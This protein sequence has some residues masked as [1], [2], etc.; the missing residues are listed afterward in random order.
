MKKLKSSL[1]HNLPPRNP[2]TNPK[3]CFS[4]CIRRPPYAL[5]YHL[6]PVSIEQSPGNTA[7]NICAAMVWL[8]DKNIR[9]L[10][11]DSRLIEMPLHS[12][13]VKTGQ[14]IFNTHDRQLG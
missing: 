14:R 12:I 11:Q 8:N 5:K 13:Q 9:I 7:R 1:R 10:P 3:P 6:L 4:L 2:P